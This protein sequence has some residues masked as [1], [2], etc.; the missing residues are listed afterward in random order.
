MKSIEDWKLIS[1]QI[2]NYL[3][4]NS[5][6][7]Y[8]IYLVGSK[9]DSEN[10]DSDF[11][12]LIIIETNT[13]QVET[14]R[15]LRKS[16]DNYI[17][18]ESI[19]ELYHF[20]LF[21]PEEIKAIAT[22]DGFRLADFQKRNLSVKNSGILDSI[23]PNLNLESLFNSFLIQLVHKFIYS[24]D[25]PNLNDIHMKLKYWIRFNLNIQE[26]IPIGS[27]TFQ[28]F[29]E[30]DLL[31]AQFWNLFHSDNRDK[32]QLRVLL[33]SYFERLKHES[34]NKYEAYIKLTT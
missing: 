32:S 14:L 24:L 16:I 26:I 18:L 3:L 10:R 2:E 23:P 22:Y 1:T 15:E 34:I 20:K 13:S 17:L 4:S 8:D 5:V 33:I 11:D 21:T 6:R 19:S 7:V 27:A 29:T 12:S 30:N 31:I 28:Y 25:N 9:V